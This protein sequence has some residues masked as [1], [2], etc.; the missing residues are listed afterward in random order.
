MRFSW[1]CK[2][3]IVIAIASLVLNIAKPGQ[4]KFLSPEQASRQLRD[5]VRE[6]GDWQK[7]DNH[8]QK[9]DSRIVEAIV[10]GCN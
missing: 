6:F 9:N 7:Q 3:A 5:V 8:C 4:G 1:P 2:M 10:G